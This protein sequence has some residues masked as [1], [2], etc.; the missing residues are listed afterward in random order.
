MFALAVGDVRQR[1]AA[2]RPRPRGQEAAL[3]R[4]RRPARWASPRSSSR[5]SPPASPAPEIDPEALDLYLAYGY[6][7]A[8]WTIFRGATQAPGRPPR[9]LRRAGVRDRALL[10]RRPP[11]RRRTPSPGADERADA[12]SSSTC[13]P[14]PCAT[15]WRATSRWAPSS[16]AGSTRATIVSLMS[17]AMAGRSAPTRSA[18][19]TAPRTSGRTPPRWRAPSAPTTWR[20][21]SGPTSPTCCRGSPGTSTSRSPIRRRCPPGTS[22]GR[23]GGG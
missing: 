18:S 6:V 10:G 5:S 13:S 17:E 9:R 2:A 21:R 7:P 4:R 19:P 3:L 22:R 16:P 14:P 8:P 11:T 12:R 15:A 23:P 1:R 20:P